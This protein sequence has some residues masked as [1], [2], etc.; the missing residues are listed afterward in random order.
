MKKIIILALVMCVS[1]AGFGQG[2]N[3]LVPYKA[4]FTKKTNGADT[5]SNTDTT[6]LV[7]PGIDI[8]G[9][10]FQADITNTKVS[11]TVGGSVIMQ[12]SN[13]FSNW[14]TV[15]NYASVVVGVSDTT[16]LTNTN[17]Q[18]FTYG[19][20]SCDFLY[21]RWRFITSGTQTSYPTGTIYWCPPMVKN[22]N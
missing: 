11:G 7:L 1:F 16:T 4:N 8:R 15:K 2:K 10:Q 5:T 3:A 6:Y 14:F 20:H 12:G 17:S 21:V 13:D 19:L 22:L 18:I 9:Y